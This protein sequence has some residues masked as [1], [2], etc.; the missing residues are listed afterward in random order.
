MLN[1][2]ETRRVASSAMIVQRRV[3]C[4]YPPNPPPRSSP[5]SSPLQ[6]LGGLFDLTGELNRFAV[7]RATERDTQGV[8]ECLETVLVVSVACIYTCICPRGLYYPP[9]GVIFPR[10]CFCSAVV[11]MVVGTVLARSPH[12]TNG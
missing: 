5:R 1:R 9:G 7:A 12:Y 2:E 3:L 11:T 8:K 10:P 6:Y 4:G